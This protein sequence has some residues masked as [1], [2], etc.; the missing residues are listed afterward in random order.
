MAGRCPSL[1]ED[2]QQL[3]DLV[4][5]GKLFALQDWIKAGKRLRT[6]ENVNG[7]NQVLS[8]AVGTG[9][10]SIVEELLRTGG[11]TVEELTDALDLA[12]AR[13]RYDIA[14]LLLSH[15]AHPKQLDFQ[16]VCRELDFTMMEHH[17]RTGINPNCDNDFARALSRVKARPLLGFYMKFRGEFPTLDDQ[18]ALAL[19]EAVQK[20][21]VRWTALLVWAGAD[22]LRLVPKDLTDNFPVDTD[23]G[24]TAAKEAIWRNNWEILKVLRLKPTPSQALELLSQAAHNNNVDLFKTLI[25]AVPAGQLNKTSRESCQPLEELVSRSVHRDLYRNIRDTEG[26]AENL[27]RVEM[28][29]DAGAR[30]NPPPDEIRY[31]RKNIMD[32][33]PRYIVQLL[34]LLLYT[35][36]AVDLDQFRELCRSQTLEAKIASVDL[37]LTYELK[38]VRTAKRP[39]SVFPDGEAKTETAPV[40]LN[41]PHTLS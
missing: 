25:A 24:T 30:W 17:L 19:S 29:L 4:K 13:R 26:E 1:P 35:P 28:L 15:G 18:A 40:A 36:N 23:N 22:P 14:D 12:R 2:L 39:I 9:F 7:D 8:I 11:W 31:T 10:H 34:R 38:T 37:P 3:L 21:Q 16:T 32:H 27:Q 6:P 33:D 20:D 5:K 41:A